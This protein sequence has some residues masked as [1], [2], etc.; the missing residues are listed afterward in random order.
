MEINTHLK[1]MHINAAPRISENETYTDVYPILMSLKDQDTYLENTDKFELSDEMNRSRAN[2]VNLWIFTKDVTYKI[3]CNITVTTAFTELFIFALYTNKIRRPKEHFVKVTI[4]N[5]QIPQKVESI[6]DTGKFI[7]ELDTLFKTSAASPIMNMRE[8]RDFIEPYDYYKTLEVAKLKEKFFSIPVNGKKDE[9]DDLR[10]VTQ[11]QSYIVD[12]KSNE[13]IT[14]KTRGEVTKNIN[15]SDIRLSESNKTVNTVKDK[16][17]VAS[18]DFSKNSLLEDRMQYLK[19]M[20]NR[21]DL[22][23]LDQKTPPE[24]KDETLSLLSQRA[25][26]RK[27]IGAEANKGDLEIVILNKNI[28][29]INELR[30]S[31]IKFNEEVKDEDNL[32]FETS[33]SSILKKLSKAIKA[34]REDNEIERNKFIPEDQV[35]EFTNL[36]TDLIKESKNLEELLTTKGAKLLDK[37]ESKSETIIDNINKFNSAIKA[38]NERISEIEEGEVK[39][40]EL[41][42]SDLE[43]KLNLEFEK[44]SSVI[45]DKINKLIEINKSNDA[46][47]SELSKELEAIEIE[48]KK[49]A[50]DEDSKKELDNL[51]KDYKKIETEIDKIEKSIKD[52][53]GK[54]NNFDSEVETLSKKLKNKLKEFRSQLDALESNEEKNAK[55]KVDLEERIEKL[56]KAISDANVELNINKGSFLKELNLLVEDELETTISIE[57]DISKIN[58]QEE[59]Y[60][61]EFK[62]YFLGK[63]TDDNYIYLLEG[64][65]VTL[66]DTIYKTIRKIQNHGM[67]N[68]LVKYVADTNVN[69]PKS[70]KYNSKS[71]YLEGLN[72]EQQVAFNNAINP[73]NP[74]SIIQGPPGTGKTEVITRI[75]KHYRDLG[76][77]VILSSQS[78]EAIQ[79]VMHK[80]INDKDGP[81]SGYWATTKED[82]MFS[83][84]QISKTWYEETFKKRIDLINSD[85][86]KEGDLDKGSENYKLIKEASSELETLETSSNPDGY[87]LDFNIY[88]NS[89]LIGATTTTSVTNYGADLDFI[90]KS[91]VLIVDEVSKSYLVEILR[92][93]LKVDKIILVGD[94][95]QLSPLF[96]INKK[97]VEH[98][99]VYNETSFESIKE[100]ITEGVFYNVTQK[101]AKS[102]L[103]TQLIQNYRSLEE[104]LKSYRT[105][106]SLSDD[107]EIDSSELE[108]FRTNDKEFETVMNKYK[109]PEKNNFFNNKAARYFVNLEN[110]KS[111]Q[112]NNKSYENITER[113]YIQT[114]LEDLLKVYK[115]PQNLSLG[116]IF[117]YAGQ[118]KLFKAQNVQLIKKLQTIFKGGFR[119]NTV[120]GYQG[121][122]SDIV[123]VATTIDLNPSTR[124]FLTNYRRLNVA[125][126]RAKDILVI[127]GS[128]NYL[129][130][131]MM[132]RDGKEKALYL[133]EVIEDI[134]TSDKSK[135]Y[136]GL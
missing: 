130:N 54:I 59:K 32:T 26:A 123:I 127:V 79:N 85:L 35:E 20:G 68:Q 29:L 135:F 50:K 55:D 91:K 114:I 89:N 113:E 103:N 119:I 69:L 136:G 52:S 67:N 60:T 115:E 40:R 63:I 49:L 70:L 5:T 87:L 94:Y 93:S 83:S 122:E 47:S 37:L 56:N 39:L 64:G 34:L 19:F 104:V 81:I 90:E 38:A 53:L 109:F 27:Y 128:E 77:K 57:N 86:V 116:L 48:I 13:T 7:K 74:L 125:L 62:Y 75:I 95:R 6:R 31:L 16:Y 45:E 132:D 25:R 88:E 12:N 105:F 15:I 133:K 97:D 8:W 112:L 66:I 65:T 84:E 33:F 36:K 99:D 23:G 80:L 11:S 30:L 101:A 134:K 111:I 121:S 22:F 82:E 92:Y 10:T 117:M 4:E 76:T 72:D 98:L 73:N 44:K 17:I 118:L 41:R 1:L 24:L 129:A 78:N 28:E 3:M 131:T 102:N 120:D 107:K 96:N 100:K 106:Y 42:E 110:T 9:E 43:N 21:L 108:A 71:K 126:S 46:K 124:T 14:F 18:D 61:Y 51:N 2:S 58:L